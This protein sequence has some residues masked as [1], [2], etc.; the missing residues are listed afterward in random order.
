VMSRLQVMIDLVNSDILRFMI[1]RF[2]PY[3]ASAQQV[4]RALGVGRVLGARAVIDR[5]LHCCRN[6]VESRQPPAPPNGEAENTKAR[7][8]DS[9]GGLFI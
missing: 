6:H 5:P 2:L 9:F 4:S 8:A 3:H 1:V 7:R